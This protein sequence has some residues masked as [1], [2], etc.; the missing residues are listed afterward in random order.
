MKSLISITKQPVRFK[1]L[2]HC[3]FTKVFQWSL[4]LYLFSIQSEIL[5]KD[6]LKTETV[7]IYFLRS[8]G[9][10]YVICYNHQWRIQ[11]PYIINQIFPQKRGGGLL[12]P[13][14]I[15]NSH[16]HNI[17]K[18]Y[19]VLFYTHEFRSTDFWDSK[20]LIKITLMLAS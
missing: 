15:T 17:L 9:V 16:Y 7:Y 18:K 10:L 12:D 5:D 19:R 1:H 6:L 3:I 2:N 13:P 11:I 8:L 20:I 14:K 4:I